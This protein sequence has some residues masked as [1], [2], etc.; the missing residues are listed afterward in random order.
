MA[1]VKYTHGGQSVSRVGVYHSSVRTLM[2]TKL[3]PVR[4]IYLAVS[5]L[6]DSGVW[7]QTRLGLAKRQSKFEIAHSTN[8]RH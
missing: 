7:S 6:V 1:H 5:K 4:V 3:K 8:L 2:T